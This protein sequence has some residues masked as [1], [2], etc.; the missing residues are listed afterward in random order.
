VIDAGS[1]NSTLRHRRRL[2]T[3]TIQRK[4]STGTFQAIHKPKK[5]KAGKYFLTLLILGSIVTAIVFY[6]DEI[7][8][9][10][11]FDKFGFSLNE[12]SN[13]NTNTQ[14]QQLP[15]EDK[16]IEE[17]K[18]FTPIQKRIQ[19]EVLNGCGASGIAKKFSDYL[20]KHNYDVVNSGNYLT[21]GRDNFNVV[22]TKIIDQLKSPENIAHANDLAD[23]LGI[24]QNLIESFENPSPIA[25]LTV[26][27][28]KD[29]NQ[30]KLKEE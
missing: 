27:I 11:P 15:V 17:Q 13:T 29:Y 5:S 26:I 14:A 18:P 30:I 2:N 12:N 28:G 10:L 16:K 1:I 3:Q 24:D 7:A 4:N 9:L 8:K 19:I 21:N 25:D 22:Q 20:K 23:I 6:K